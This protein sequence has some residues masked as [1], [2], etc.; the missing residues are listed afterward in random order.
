MGQAAME[1][2]LE[3]MRSGE[4]QTQPRKIMLPTRIEMRASCGPCPAL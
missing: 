3:T 1:L 4:A 2:L